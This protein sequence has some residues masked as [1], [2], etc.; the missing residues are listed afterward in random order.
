MTRR[1]RLLALAA[2]LS[3]T[4][5]VRTAAAQTV[6]VRGAAPG[7]TVE[8]LINSDRA[9][10]ATADP[11]GLATLVG[12]KPA[13]A[14]GTETSARVVVDTCGNLHRI[15]LVDN[16]LQPPG[17]EGACERQAVP[18]LFVVRPITTFVVNVGGGSA[19]VYV[20]QGPAP[21]AWIGHEEETKARE[22][23]VAPAGLMLQGAVGL[24]Q[25]SS[26]VDVAC[27][28]AP[29]CSDQKGGGALGAGVAFWLTRNIALGAE[30]LRPADL[31][32]TG[33]GD[34]F[35]FSS[36]LKTRVSLF[37]ARVGG[38]A[39][40]VRLYGLGGAT[41]QSAIWSTT[42]T[43]DTTAARAGGT[44]TMAFKATGWGWVAGGGLETWASSR[45]GFYI[46]GARVAL[47]ASAV[48]NG[49][50]SIDDQMIYFVGGIR[51]HVWK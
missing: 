37:T 15:M 20:R 43:A 34:D 29:T 36:V 35:K 2:G 7:S 11:E 25:Y 31:I 22:W 26:V 38:Q 40:P 8:L 21:P 32:V 42:Q 46:E 17:V 23:V 3:V 9:A 50:G 49:E 27:G 12:N 28:D 1:W 13:A 10:T 4:V 24:M 14:P 44:E 18:T 16:G 19:S 30:A 6:I 45:I 5:G 33:S 41:Y 48:D 51:L 39:G 47:K